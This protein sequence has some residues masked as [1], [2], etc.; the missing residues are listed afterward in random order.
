MNEFDF[1]DE[2]LEAGV[3]DKESSQA[4]LASLVT[5]MAKQQMALAKLKAETA[6]ASEDLNRTT[7]KLIPDLMQSLDCKSFETFSGLK[8]SLKDKVTAK[9]TDKTREG[10]VNWLKKA[11]K[12]KILTHEFTLNIKASKDSEEK[13]KKAKAALDASGFDYT[14][15]K[16]V[17]HTTLGAVVREMYANGEAVPEALFNVYRYKEAK[18][19]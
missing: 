18:I 6:K 12:D 8:I 3:V 13:V 14:D 1:G 17:H 11:N 19:G 9:I 2:E 7:R 5:L 16:V 15:K 10:A 4:Q